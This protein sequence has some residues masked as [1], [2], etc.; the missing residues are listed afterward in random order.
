MKQAVACSGMPATKQS[1]S[2]VRLHKACTWSLLPELFCSPAADTTA[3]LMWRLRNGELPTVN[4]PRLVVIQTG[5]NDVD[6]AFAG[7]NDR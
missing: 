1:I 4:I 6:V 5:G 3:S 7:V 2:L